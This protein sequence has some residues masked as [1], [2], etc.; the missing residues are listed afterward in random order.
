[1]VMLKFLLLALIV[2][3]LGGIGWRITEEYLE[4]R[5]NKEE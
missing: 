1:M 4:K 5:S 3:T 2:G